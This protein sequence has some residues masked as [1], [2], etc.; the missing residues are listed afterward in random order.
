[1]EEKHIMKVGWEEVLDTRSGGSQVKTTQSRQPRNRSGQN[2]Y[3]VYMCVTMG[4]LC[5]Q[6]HVMCLLLTDKT[7]TKDKSYIELFVYYESIKREV[8]RRLIYE[9]RCDER[10]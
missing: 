4:N 1:M 6:K 2:R 3:P 7:R 5:V 9:Y 10:V 8:K